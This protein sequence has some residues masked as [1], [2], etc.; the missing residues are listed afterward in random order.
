[1]IN[2]ED[3][4]GV[5][6]LSV[7]GD[8]TGDECAKVRTVVEQSIDQ[9]HVVNFAVDLEK[10]TYLDSEGLETVCWIKAK[11]DELF[12]MMKLVAPDETCRKIL[13]MT[14]LDE[15]LEIEVDIS[16]ALKAMR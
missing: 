15:R 16:T 9:R 14:R 7:A 1:M 3:Y 11:C 12:G 4:N 8:L 10:C 2:S 6:V 13:E 5:C